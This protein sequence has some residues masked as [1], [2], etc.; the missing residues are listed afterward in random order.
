MKGCTSEIDLCFA[1]LALA[2]ISSDVLTPEEA[3]EKIEGGRLNQPNRYT[4]PDD[5]DEMIAEMAEMREY[6]W[7]YEEIGYAFLISGE[8]VSARLKRA[9]CRPTVT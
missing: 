8:A 2:I 1:A 5:A 6:G 9:G 3:F 7:T 4:R